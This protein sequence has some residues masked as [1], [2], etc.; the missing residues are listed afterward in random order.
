MSPKEC[1]LITATSPAST[2]RVI[3]SSAG[4]DITRVQTTVADCGPRSTH[5]PTSPVMSRM[6]GQMR[7]RP[8]NSSASACSGAHGASKYSTR[9][10]VGTRAAAVPRPANMT[11]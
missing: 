1:G 10:W 4:T 3:A 5:T 6:V 7:C 11:W 2:A 8:A 9:A